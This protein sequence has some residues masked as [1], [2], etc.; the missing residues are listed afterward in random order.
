MRR[1]RRTG[2]LR[3][4]LRRE[5]A[6]MCVRFRMIAYYNQTGSENMDWSD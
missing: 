1:A 5:A 6:N 2:Q 4:N 3:R